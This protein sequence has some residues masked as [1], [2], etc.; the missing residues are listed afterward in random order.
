MSAQG[1]ALA[2]SRLAHLRAELGQRCID[3]GRTDDLT[4][5]VILPLGDRHGDKSQDVRALIY[6]QEHAKGNLARRCRSCNA[7][8]GWSFDRPFYQTMAMI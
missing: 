1:K 4:F 3:C 2:R 8:K 6:V 5:D 7:K